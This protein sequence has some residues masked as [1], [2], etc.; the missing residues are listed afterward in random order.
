MIIALTMN[1]DMGVNETWECM[2]RLQ[3]SPTMSSRIEFRHGTCCLAVAPRGQLASKKIELCLQAK[4]PFV[5]VHKLSHLCNHV[6]RHGPAH[7]VCHPHSCPDQMD[8][9]T[10]Q[11][12]S[13]QRP[14]PWLFVRTANVTVT[15]PGAAPQAPELYGRPF[16]LHRS[17]GHSRP[18]VQRD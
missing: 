11:T 1:P 3:H 5:S 4:P 14:E 15:V 17:G 7:T 18:Q 16:H 12:S 6:E 2:P 9:A 8:Q 10:Q 13:D